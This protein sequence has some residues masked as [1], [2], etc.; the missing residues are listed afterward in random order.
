M[1]KIKK[2]HGLKQ[3]NELSIISFYADVPGKTLQGVSNNKKVSRGES[4]DSISTDLNLWQLHFLILKI[5]N[6]KYIV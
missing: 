6:W 4:H 2:N 3:W 1:L 5:L